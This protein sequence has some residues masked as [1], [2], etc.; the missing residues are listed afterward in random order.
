LNASFVSNSADVGGAFWVE[1]DLALEL[2]SATDNAATTGASVVELL[3]GTAAFVD[4]DLGAP[5]GP[6]NTSPEVSLEARD[7]DFEGVTTVRCTPRRMLN[8]TQATGEL[9]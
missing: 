3:A 9:G 8:L 7:V 5:G 1:G 2:G 6:D 4:V